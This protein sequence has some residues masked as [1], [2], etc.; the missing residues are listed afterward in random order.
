MDGIH[1]LGGKHGYG[2][3][4]REPAAP[5]A[6]GEPAFHE[7]AFHERWEAKVFTMSR[8]PGAIGANNNTDRFRHAVERMDP[9]AYLTHTYYGRW[10]AAIETLLVE[11]GVLTSEEITRRTVELGG[12]DNDLVGARPKD[13]PDPLAEVLAAPSAA[14]ELGRGGRFSVGDRVVT[15]TDVK[16]GHTRLPGYARGKAGRIRV[17]HA[18]W[19]YP[20]TNA[21]GLGE[22]PQHLYTVE[23]TGVVLWGKDADPALKVHLDLFEPYLEPNFS[24]S[25]Y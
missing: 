24:S 2:R 8:V 14:R 19:V 10:L 7:P 23:F 22:N 21:H 13:T 11:G 5:T 4:A 17:C 16:P 12:R 18:G 15:A 9:V 3:V 1:D 6:G 20:D 25:D